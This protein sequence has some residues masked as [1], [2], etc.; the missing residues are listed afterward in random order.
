MSKKIAIAADHGGFSL[1]EKIKKS[2]KKY[3]FIDT[4]TFSL[5]PCDYPLFGFE[6]AKMVSKKKATRGIVICKTGIGMCVVANKLPGVRAGVCLTKEDAKSGREHND[7]NVLVLARVCLNS[8]YID[9]IAAVDSCISVKDATDQFMSELQKSG[10]KG[11]EVDT[12]KREYKPVR[13]RQLPGVQEKL[14]DLLAQAEVIFGTLLFPENL[15][16]RAPRLKWIH[17]ASSGIDQYRSSGIFS[18]LVYLLFY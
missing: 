17:L 10:R 4:G 9:D 2:L 5:D 12:F 8:D 3:S 16:I 11:S 15:L 7:I 6:A 14:D 18:R 1:K 13:D